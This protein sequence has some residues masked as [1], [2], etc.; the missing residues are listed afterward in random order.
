MKIASN[1]FDSDFSDSDNRII[2]GNKMINH[3][4]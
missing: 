3:E 4:A 1:N 2:M